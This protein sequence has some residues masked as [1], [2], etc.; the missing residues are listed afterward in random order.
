MLQRV[1]HVSAG[2]LGG[3][4][5]YRQN[6]DGV[7][8]C[9][10][11]ID[12]GHA[13]IQSTRHHQPQHAACS[14]ARRVLRKIIWCRSRGMSKR[15]AMARIWPD[16]MAALHLLPRPPPLEQTQASEPD[17]DESQ[18]RL[19]KMRAYLQA[20]RHLHGISAYAQTHLGR[21]ALEREAL[22]VEAD[23]PALNKTLA[24]NRYFMLGVV[25][26]YPT[27]GELGAL[28]RECARYWEVVRAEHNW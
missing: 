16:A 19:E 11:A 7:G 17:L 2:G 8:Y 9:R 24:N 20:R 4:G 6:A 5:E 28:W 13:A 26:H 22:F 12:D 1:W 25:Q 27:L 21:L 23:T 3:M 14:D 15:D 10:Y 18:R